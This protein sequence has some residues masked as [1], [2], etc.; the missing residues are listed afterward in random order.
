MSKIEKY[1]TLDPTQFEQEWSEYPNSFEVEILQHPEETVR[2][3][4]MIA[5]QIQIRNNDLLSEIDDLKFRSVKFHKFLES[6]LVFL[7]HV[8]E[9]Y[10][11]LVARLVVGDSS[12]ELAKPQDGGKIKHFLGTNIDQ[13]INTYYSGV[14]TT[15]LHG[16][17]DP[18]EKSLNLQ[19]KIMSL[20][21]SINGSDDASA[22]HV[23]ILFNI[24]SNKTNSIALTKKILVLETPFHNITNIKKRLVHFLKYSFSIQSIQLH[25]LCKKF[26]RER[27]DPE[28]IVIELLNLIKKESSNNR[29]SSRASDGKTLLHFFCQL[30]YSSCVEYII[31]IDGATVHVLDNNLRSPLFYAVECTNLPCVKI[32]INAGAKCNIKDIKNNS[33]IEYALRTQDVEIM[34]LLSNSVDY[35][36]ATSTTELEDPVILGNATEQK[37]YTELLESTTDST[38]DEISK[39][40]NYNGASLLHVSSFLNNSECL[41]KYLELKP[42]L[43]NSLDKNQTTPLH[44]AVAKGSLSCV[45]ILLGAK[46]D[47]NL[48]DLNKATPLNICCCFNYVDVAIELLKA[49][50]KVNQQ[51][52]FGYSPLHN[53]C[54]G[55]F[56]NMVKVLL[57]HKADVEQTRGNNELTPLHH[58]SKHGHLP[59]I[60]ILLDHGVKVEVGKNKK[61]LHYSA[62]F[63]WTKCAAYLI[64]HG[65]DV[66]SKDK[67]DSVPLHHAATSGSLDICKLLIKKSADIESLNNKKYSPLM[68][69]ASSGNSQCVKLFINLKAKVDNIS[70][71]GETALYLAASSGHLSTVKQLL[72]HSEA[73]V[74]IP[75]GP[76]GN[77]A[78]HAACYNGYLDIM[79]VICRHKASSY[80][81]N[82][83]GISVLIASLASYKCTEYLLSRNVPI[84]E[85]D[86]EG[87]S[88]LYHAIE[89]QFFK[90]AYLLIEKGA[91]VTLCDKKGVKALDLVP[92]QY[93][94]FI[95]DAVKSRDETKNQPIYDEA[96]KKFNVKAESG[97]DYLVNSNIL[98]RT[99]QDFAWFL[100]KMNKNL[101]KKQIGLYLGDEKDFN[102]NTLVALTAKL[103]FEGVRFDKAIRQYLQLF[104]LPGESQKIG[105]MMQCF[106]D[107][108]FENNP[109]IFP[110]QDTAMVLAFSL[111][112]LNTDLHNPNVKKKMNLDEFI[113]NSRGTWGP[114]FENPPRDL[115]ETLYYAIAEEEIQ[116]ENEEEINRKGYMKKISSSTTSSSKRLW[117]VLKENCLF[118]FNESTDESPSGIIPMENINVV[119][120]GDKRIKLSSKDGG[121]VK[122]CKASRYGHGM[123]QGT[124]HEITLSTD[125]ASRDKWL[126]ALQFNVKV[127]PIIEHILKRAKEQRESKLSSASSSSTSPSNNRHVEKYT[128]KKTFTHYLNCARLCKCALESKKNLIKTYGTDLK[129]FKKGEIRYFM[130]NNK[131]LKKQQIVLSGNMWNEHLKDHVKLNKSARYDF[132]NHLDIRNH[133]AE[134]RNE[135][136]DV[137]RKEYEIEISGYGLGSIVA[138]FL[139]L[140]LSESSYNVTSVVTFGQPSVVSSKDFYS[141]CNLKVMRIIL[142]KDPA[143]YFF[144]QCAHGGL[145][146]NLG[147]YTNVVWMDDLGRQ[148]VEEPGL[149]KFLK[150]Q[151]LELAV[152][153]S[154]IK[155]YIEK[156]EHLSGNTGGHN[157]SSSSSPPPSKSNTTTTK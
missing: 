75:C 58:A 14:N 53:A 22:Q 72:Y 95:I 19:F 123:V 67:H 110:D 155:T 77:T 93:K 9:T 148:M 65:A 40:I 69:A 121:P 106:A 1:P 141:S 21:A 108:Y 117:F 146:M 122:Y 150:K 98:E 78:L 130:L 46:A 144:E 73:D 140:G 36:L 102:K 107:R 29:W 55:G 143:R 61:P 133:L 103:N 135:I 132:F 15:S 50:A 81:K 85:V 126:Q 4:E 82:K 94:D 25:S 100:L 31:S 24:V 33:L 83:E 114:Q 68:I 23:R 16:H 49:S 128:T 12:L 153:R 88:A 43:I 125:L 60:E 32:L 35:D 37:L 152:E 7:V 30:G 86:N 8:N 119:A 157:S 56:A 38:I 112:M 92:S 139:A 156:L 28:E 149:V 138:I 70:V 13:N 66:N 64:E 42:N 129:L 51:D 104:M 116:F 84:D 113:N 18:V 151:S 120:V 154:S 111:I 101:D 41:K 39:W 17:I 142:N 99:P 105:R 127:N 54:A 62:K 131:K 115:C 71:D 3:G 134:V 145:Q 11:Y 34:Q 44:Q 90:V 74:N 147:K 87:K 47:P 48:M 57:E 20:P 26:L 76:V 2:P 59:I 5:V 91:D 96:V 109:H 137:L 45:R 136:S 118:Y 6:G 63:G 52:K 80:L 97:L 89:K 10:F 27:D 124:Q 79:K